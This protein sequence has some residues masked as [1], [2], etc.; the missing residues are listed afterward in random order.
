VT[1]KYVTVSLRYTLNLRDD[2][3]FV[4]VAKLEDDAM[5]PFYKVSG[6]LWEPKPR[7]YQISYN[8]LI[9]Y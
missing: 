2:S 9:V 1:P 8:Y 7:A 5:A 4:K 6:G 3:S